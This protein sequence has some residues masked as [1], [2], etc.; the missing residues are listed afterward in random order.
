MLDATGGLNGLR[1]DKGDNMGDDMEA[2]VSRLH[3]FLRQTLNY[4]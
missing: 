2:Q 4:G 1:D 3:E